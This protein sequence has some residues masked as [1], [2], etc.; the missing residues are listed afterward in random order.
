MP[1]TTLVVPGNCA[2]DPLYVPEIKKVQ[3][4]FGPSGKTFAMDCK[5][6]SLGTRAYLASTRDYYLGP[7]SET[8]VSADQRR[9]LL[10]P[11]WQGQQKLAQVYRPGEEGQDE[12][13][14]AEGFCLDV[15]LAGEVDDKQV[16]WTE[17]RWLVRSLAYAAGQH[18]QLD[19]RL[20]T[21]AE[22]LAGL[23]E[24]KQGKKRLTAQEMAEA[25]QE[26]VSKHRVQD[27]L[28]YQVRTTTHKRKVRAYGDR[29]ARVEKEQEQRL[30]VSRR[31]E[32]IEQAKREMGWRVY[33]TNQKSLNLA[34]VVW[35]YRG[36]NRLEDN[37]ARLKGQPLGLTPMYLQYES[38]IMGLVLLLSI[39]LRLLS[40]LEW[41]LRKKLQEQGQTLKGLYPGQPGRQAK[42]P[43]AELLLGAFQGINLTVLLVA[44]HQVTCITT[45]SALQLRLLELWE[46]PPDLYLRLTLHFSEPPPI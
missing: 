35:G 21:A 37:Y 11:V 16:Q 40:V 22:Q 26:I 45:L 23:G 33:A 7:L 38:R 39:A 14:V 34:A 20:Q 6:M 32:V 28:D 17:Q 18:K 19:R 36:Q 15:P 43:S 4:A 13:L 42:R 1:V 12:E 25:A 3:L 5:G 10:Q 44:G 27:M 30:E 2:D 41:S 31:E 9:A 29:P 46:L 24:R 8:H